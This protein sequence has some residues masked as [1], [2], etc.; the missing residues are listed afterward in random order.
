M[1]II[2]ILISGVS[3]VR[4]DDL[5]CT[6]VAENEEALE[7]LVLFGDSKTLALALDNGLSLEAEV[8]S[9]GERRPLLHTAV[10][11]ERAEIVEL[12]MFR[13]ANSDRRDRYWYRPIEYL[14]LAENFKVPQP[15][16]MQGHD[17]YSFDNRISELLARPPPKFLSEEEKLSHVAEVVFL[18]RGINTK[19]LLLKPEFVNRRTGQS[20]C[21]FVIAKGE[22][23]GEGL[24]EFSYRLELNTLDPMN[25]YKYKLEYLYEDEDTG[26]SLGDVYLVDGYWLAEQTDSVVY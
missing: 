8:L 14:H 21:L 17:T 6:S 25:H 11:F 7:N 4:L 23:I 10:L 12:L 3:C 19:A 1:L 16:A 22:L 26:V 13:G 9:M 24:Q 2:L 20:S 5:Y 15:K 18:R